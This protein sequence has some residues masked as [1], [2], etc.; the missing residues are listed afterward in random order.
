MTRAVRTIITPGLNSI[1]VPGFRIDT[2]LDVGGSPAPGTVKS[3][4]LADEALAWEAECF[5]LFMDTCLVTID[6]EQDMI[7]A[8]G[9][10]VRT[11]VA[12][13]ISPSRW[14]A[15]PALYEDLERTRFGWK[16]HDT[17]FQNWDLNAA[18]IDSL[19]DFR[20]E[21]YGEGNT[22]S[23]VQVFQYLWQPLWP[24]ASRH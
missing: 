4:A 8:V 6:N 20:S 16:H 17:G 7:K 10:Y 5:K 13:R 18:K 2:V 1:Q 9:S 22:S 24:W 11:L 21:I 3:Q 15:A 12:D 14:S 19:E 23:R